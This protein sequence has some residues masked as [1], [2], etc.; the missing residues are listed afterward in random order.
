MYQMASI[1]AVNR[2][3]RLKFALFKY[4]Q[5]ECIGRYWGY[6]NHRRY[7]SNTIG[8]LEESKVSNVCEG[9]LGIKYIEGIECIEG[10]SSKPQKEDLTPA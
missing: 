8:L 2:S 10:K 1:K 3:Q 9:I 6:W 5:I 7:W 4:F